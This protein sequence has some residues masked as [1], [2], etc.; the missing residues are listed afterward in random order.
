MVK[1]WRLEVTDR[2]LALICPYNT[3]KCFS[4]FF[5]ILIF[6]DFMAQGKKLSKM[7]KHPVLPTPY[8]RNC[9]SWL[10]FLVH[11]C[12]MIMYP[13][14]FFIFSKFCFFFFFFFCGGRRKG[15]KLTQLYLFQSVML[16]LSRIVD[17]IY[18]LDFWYIRRGRGYEWRSSDSALGYF[19]SKITSQH[20]ILYKKSSFIIFG[21]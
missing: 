17:H 9:K 8:L 18:H 7:T 1:D 3:S 11:I 14:I 6:W 10:W 2:W 19:I 20:K 15:K 16:H 4:H 5:K 13:A 12:K 21:G